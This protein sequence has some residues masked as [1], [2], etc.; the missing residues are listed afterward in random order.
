MMRVLWENL[1][2]PSYWVDVCVTIAFE[3]APT[4]HTFTMI[5]DTPNTWRTFTYLRYGIDDWILKQ[6]W[7]LLDTEIDVCKHGNDLDLNSFGPI[8]YC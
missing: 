2:K 5:I 3:F 8:F 1:L 7:F 6:L 4:I